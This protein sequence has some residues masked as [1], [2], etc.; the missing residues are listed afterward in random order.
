MLSNVYNGSVCSLRPGAEVD[1][2]R[3]RGLRKGGEVKEFVLTQQ[4]EANPQAT[5]RDDHDARDLL[6]LNFMK[7]ASPH[8]VA[9]AAQ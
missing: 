5:R 8:A 9:V 6:A 3:D 2:P 4:E 1:D 7:G